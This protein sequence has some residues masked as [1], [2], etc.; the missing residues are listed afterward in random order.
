MSPILSEGVAMLMRE[1]ARDVV[2]PRFR[3]L[4][5]HQISEKAPGDVVTIV[6]HE[7]EAR[8]AEGLA[9]LLPEARIVGEEAAA[10]EPALLDG[11]GEGTCWLVD[12][13]DGT[14]NFAEGKPP[15]AL[16]IALI[17]DGETIAGWI[18]DPVASRTCF[19]APGRGA[20]VNGD[21]IVTHTSPRP[22]PIA[23]IGLY[24]MDEEQRGD[25]AARAEDKLTIA[26][27][28]RCAG[29][30]Y[31]RIALGTNDISLFARTL[32]YDH[33]AGA[34]FLDEAGGKTAWADGT[35]YRVTQRRPN[36]LS[37]ATPAL[38]ERAAEILFA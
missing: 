15:F 36:L 33:A 18:Y 27:I 22:H 8:L 31:P 26:T 13:L 1:V 35:P 32:P 28:P 37:A 38:W 20:Y 34:L 12:P 9:E 2:L 16:M 30:Q 14:A 25:I 11:L 10:E 19:A 21:R 7:S 5:A 24:F 3:Q 6:D 29:E 17:A 23:A 4:A